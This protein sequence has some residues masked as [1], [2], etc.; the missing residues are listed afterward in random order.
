MA[1]AIYFHQSVTGWALSRLGFTWP[2]CLEKV[3]QKKTSLLDGGEFN[4]ECVCVCVCLLAAAV[5]R[6]CK[7]NSLLQLSRHKVPY[8]MSHAMS[9]E[10]RGT[11]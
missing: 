4:G 9:N 6:A 10:S 2:G 7:S 8:Q 1:I 3:N 5:A 11:C